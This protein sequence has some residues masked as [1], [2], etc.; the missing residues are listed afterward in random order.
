MET[1]TYDIRALIPKFLRAD[2]NGA[3]MAAAISAAL[4]QFTAAVE[5]ADSL[6]CDVDAMPE[7]ALDEA[8]WGSAMPWYDFTADT[9]AKRGWVRN[10]EEIRAMIGTKGAIRRLLLGIYARCAVEECWEYGGDPHHFRVTVEGEYSAQ[11]NAWALKTIAAIKPLRS[12]LDGIAIGARATITARSEESM[13][14]MRYARCGAAVC[15]QAGL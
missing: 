13:G 5:Q 3:A 12:V 9:L 11:K 1:L 15:G 4:A 6:L 10:A 8:A 2:R 7:W 14:A